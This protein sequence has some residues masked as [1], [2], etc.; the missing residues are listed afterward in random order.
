MVCHSATE[1][2]IEVVP[3]LLLSTTPRENQ[4][5]KPSDPSDVVNSQSSSGDEKEKGS[6][7]QVALCLLRSLQIMSG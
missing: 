5:V 4:L 1:G 2:E 3:P 6:S 7:E